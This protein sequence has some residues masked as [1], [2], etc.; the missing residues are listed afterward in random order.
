MLKRKRPRQFRVYLAHESSIDDPFRGME[1]LLPQGPLREERFQFGERIAISRRAEFLLVDDPGATEVQAPAGS[2]EIYLKVVRRKLFG[3][4]Y[5]HAEP[6]GPPPRGCVLSGRTGR[7]V[8]GGVDTIHIS[9]RPIPLR[10][11][12][13]APLRPKGG[14]A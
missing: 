11:W 8:W 13:K 2:D 7:F 10:Y 14:T 6:L 5:V 3:R 1:Y 4:V 12:I 9:P